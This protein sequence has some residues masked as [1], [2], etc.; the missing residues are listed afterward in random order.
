MAGTEQI[1]ADVFATAK[2]ITGGFFLVGRDVDRGE[3]TGAIEDGEL[4]GIAAIGF[5]AIAGPA[6]N[7]GGRDDVTRHVLRGERAL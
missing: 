3:R 6:R 2:E 5:D 1:G 4:T 7:Q